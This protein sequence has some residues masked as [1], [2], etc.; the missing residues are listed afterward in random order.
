M[1]GEFTILDIVAVA[2]FFGVW[3]VYQMC[4]DGRRRR[5]TSI[6]AQMVGLRR[7]WMRRLLVRDNRVVDSTLVGHT[8]HS[9]AF[10]ASTTMLVLAGLIGVLGS[11]DQVYAAVKNITVLLGGGQRLFEWKLVLLIGIFMY[12]FFKFTW[13]LRQFNYF[14]AVIGSA[15][16]ARTDPVDADA[17]ADRMTA[18]LSHA[19]GELNSGV[20]AYYFAFAAFGWFIH[21]LAFIAATLL[22]VV[23]LARRQLTS[24]TAHAIREHV[25]TLSRH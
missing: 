9:A 14:C 25:A 2:I 20:R 18:V 24:P 13:A 3:F 1:P 5:P 23:I 4:F 8:I 12:A 15:P 17:C 19:V 6:N 7:E 10:F 11:A 16:D 22:M 21:P